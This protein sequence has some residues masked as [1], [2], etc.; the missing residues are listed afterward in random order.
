MKETVQSGK[1][2]NSSKGD[3]PKGASK[4]VTLAPLNFN[5]ALDNLLQVAPEP[6]A[7]PVKKKSAT[8]LKK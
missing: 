7:N 6:K 8:K 3:K 1:K 2:I 5:D 4:P